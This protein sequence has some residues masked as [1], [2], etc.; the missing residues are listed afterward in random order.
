MA[1]SIDDID[2]LLYQLLTWQRRRAIADSSG[3]S[4]WTAIKGGTAEYQFVPSQQI[5]SEGF[6]AYLKK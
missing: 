3:S 4:F 5:C 6:F 2:T 1:G